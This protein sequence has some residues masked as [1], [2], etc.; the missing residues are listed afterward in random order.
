LVC[1]VPLTAFVLLST[2]RAAGR[3]KIYHWR[4]IRYHIAGPHEVRMES[5]APYVDVA[6]QVEP[7]PAAS[8]M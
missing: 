8:T 5:Y 1:A 3:L 7:A 4:G 6:V 2:L